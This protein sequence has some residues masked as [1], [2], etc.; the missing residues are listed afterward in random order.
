M[1]LEKGFIDHVLAQAKV[2]KADQNIEISC[3]KEALMRF[4]TYQMASGV[5]GLAQE[6]L[7][8][9]KN[10]I[11][12]LLNNTYLRS[13]ISHEE[14]VKSKKVFVGERA[15]MTASFNQAS[16]KFWKPAQ[17]FF[18]S[19]FPFLLKKLSFFVHITN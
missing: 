5:V 18:T 9:R 2:I 8:F 3:T 11:H 15:K 7:V 4:I 16:M 14:L 19:I 13:L 17:Y 12:G 10:D 1:F 6:T